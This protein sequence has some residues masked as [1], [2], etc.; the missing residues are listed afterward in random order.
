MNEWSIVAGF[1]AGL[2]GSVHCVAMCGGLVGVIA[3][4]MKTAFGRAA[5]YWSG[6][7]S[8][9]IVSYSVAGL[10]AGGLASQVTDLFPMLR[11]H[12]IAPM[13]AGTFMVIL[14]GH[15]AQ[16]WNLLSVIEK[17]GGRL[18]NRIVPEFS[19]ILP[20]RLLRHAFVGGLLWGWIPCG[21]VYSTLVLAG[22][23][24]DPI[25][26]G[27]TMLAFGIGTLP[28]L[29]LMGAVAD[30]ITKLKSMRWPRTVVGAGICVFGSLIIVGMLPIHVG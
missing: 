4:S 14:G 20:P 24:A 3:S 22:S 29:F 21:L 19:K 6:Y 5:V 11:A 27:L 10:V 15:I 1:V 18:W 7:H 28:M 13:I 23:T 26:G 30:R 25:Q 2:A 16:W 17:A 8:G 9:R 12:S